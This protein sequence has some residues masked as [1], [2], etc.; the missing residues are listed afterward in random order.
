MSEDHNNNKN[1]FYFTQFNWLDFFFLLH[2]II[3]IPHHTT[4]TFTYIFN[5]L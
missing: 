2:L 3:T 4:K 5:T 1:D